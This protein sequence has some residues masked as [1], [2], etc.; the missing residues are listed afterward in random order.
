MKGALGV[1]LAFFIG[2]GCRLAEIPLPATPVLIGA[3]VV[4]AMT[5]GYVIVD[6]FVSTR[7]AQHRDMCGGPDGRVARQQDDRKTI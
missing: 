6:C 3:A 5:L 1:A 7:T 2:V 4:L